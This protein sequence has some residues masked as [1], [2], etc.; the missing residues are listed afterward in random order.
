M[1]EA[2]F[3]SSDITASSAPNRTSKRPPLASKA[4]GKPLKGFHGRFLQPSGFDESSYAKEAV[5]HSRGEL[6]LT[7][8]GS[9]DFLD[10]NENLKLSELLEY[11]NT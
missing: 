8:M 3:N 9:N 5:D 4:L 6:I 10:N 11:K 2:W 1:I 7:E